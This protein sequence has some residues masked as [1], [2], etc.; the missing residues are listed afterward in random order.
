MYRFQIWAQTQAGESIAL[1]GST[2]ELGLWNLKK[3]V[4]LHTKPDLYPLWYTEPAIDFS[5]CQ[6]SSDGQKIEY[7]YVRVAANGSVQWES[8]GVNRWVSLDSGYPSNTIVIDDG[9]FGYLQPCPFGYL[10]EPACKISHPNST[11]LKILVIGS[12]VAEGYKAWL[13]KGWAGLLGESLQQQYGHQLVNVSELGANVSRTLDRFPF[14]VSPEQPDVVI[15]ALSLGN[16][17]L[18]TCSPQDRRAIQRRFESGLQ[19]LIKLTR[20]L[21]ARPIL[22]SV[23]PHNDYSPEHYWLLQDTHSRMLGWGVPVLDWLASVDDGRGRWREGLS[24]DP[25]HPNTKGHRYMFQ[26]IDLSLFQIDMAELAAEKQQFWQQDEKPVYLDQSGFQVSARIEE[27]QLRIRNPSPLTYTIAPYWQELQASLRHARLIPGL[28]V[29]N[30]TE[31]GTLP[32]FAVQE[33]GKIETTLTIPPGIDQ[34]YTSAFDLFSPNNSQVLF[35]D[36]HLGILK[37]KRSPDLDHQRIRSRVQCP[38]HVEG[39]ANC[40]KSFTRGGV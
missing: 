20:K 12:S 17:G 21:G 39:S 16:E 24:F 40:L 23:Y 10:A 32:F 15:I 36:G 25:A 31:S 26:A 35:Y 30:K 33:D 38:S 22:G 29:A 13:L 7:Q 9:A 3:R 28:Y 1:V 34:E 4:H 8:V 11:G 2:P 6:S 14:V 18:A 37:K 19:Q 27:K 5:K